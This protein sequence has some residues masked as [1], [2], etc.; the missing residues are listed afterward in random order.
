[1]FISLP[2]FL[3]ADAYV[4]LTGQVYYLMDLWKPDGFEKRDS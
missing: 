3:L 1:M 4:R 2:P